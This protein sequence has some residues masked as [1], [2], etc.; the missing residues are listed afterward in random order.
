MDIIPTVLECGWLFRFYYRIHISF[1]TTKVFLLRMGPKRYLI[2][3][4]PF[5]G[6]YRKPV[7]RKNV[8][9][10]FLADVSAE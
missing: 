7:Y 2:L 5:I 9:S 10:L 1:D 8:L 4:C 6:H 3:P